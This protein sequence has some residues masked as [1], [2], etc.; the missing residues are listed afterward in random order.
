LVSRLPQRGQ[1]TRRFSHPEASYP[2]V[3]RIRTAKDM[4]DLG[5]RTTVGPTQLDAVGFRLSLFRAHTPD[6]AMEC[7]PGVDQSPSFASLAKTAMVRRDA[8]SE[9]TF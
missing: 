9:R 4:A 8:L 7:E 6:F 1:R 5:F 3:Y 2:V